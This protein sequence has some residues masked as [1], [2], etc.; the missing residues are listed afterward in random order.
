MIRLN[1]WIAVFSAIGL[2]WY[3]CGEDLLIFCYRMGCGAVATA[4]PRV[5]ELA[6]VQSILRTSLRNN[7]ACS[8]PSF[9]FSAR[10]TTPKD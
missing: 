10:S 4:R 5:L 9:T 1:A 7:V 3:E 2:L 6:P 8:N